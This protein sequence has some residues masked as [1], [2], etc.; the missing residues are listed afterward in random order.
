MHTPPLLCSTGAVNPLGSRSDWSPSSWL[1]SIARTAPSTQ[2]NPCA[3]TVEITISIG[4]MYLTI[5]IRNTYVCFLKS[6]LGF[7][8][9][10]HHISCMSHHVFLTHTYTHIQTH[11]SSCQIMYNYWLNLPLDFPLICETL[12]FVGKQLQD[13]MS[14][15]IISRNL[16]GLINLLCNT[17]LSK[18]FAAFPSLESVFLE[19]AAVLIHCAFELTSGSF[20]SGCGFW[21]NILHWIMSHPSTHT[22]TG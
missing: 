1:R 22:R 13:N 8:V 6:Y 16:H 20:L 7:S 2:L 19:L 10:L 12:D 17:D 3:M 9:F 4:K 18:W 5:D 21:R 11:W 15:N 14:A